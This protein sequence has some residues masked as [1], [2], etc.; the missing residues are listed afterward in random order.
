MTTSASACRRAVSHFFFEMTSSK[1][2]VPMR[3]TLGLS[4]FVYYLFSYNNF[5]LIFSNQGV[6]GYARPELA[7]LFDID[8]VRVIWVMAIVSALSFAVGFKTRVSGVAF[9]FCNFYLS[10]AC[11]I[12]SW[13]WY[14]IAKPFFLFTLLANPG[15][16]VSV[17][18]W[19]ARKKGLVLDGS[20]LMF[21]MRLI[22]LHAS[23]IY[24]AASV[25]RLNDPG[26][27]RGDM[28]FFA[29]DFNLYTR[30]PYVDFF[31]LKPFLAPFCWG[32]WVIE[33]LGIF[34][35]W[36][37]RIRRP[38]LVVLMAMHLGLELLTTTGRWQLIMVAVLMTIYF[39]FP[40]PPKRVKMP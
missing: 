27:L 1:A 38:V 7:A 19:L 37:G 35:P 33:F 20:M 40:A 9:L 26:W 8:L 14:R 10:Y 16:F 29:V 32:A 36:W 21:P 3:V 15:A 30:F 17:D 31:A 2:L 4:Y 39:G 24:L 34:A 23:S 18:A 5:A 12:Q 28:V 13:G 11:E 22:Q 25:H 6:P